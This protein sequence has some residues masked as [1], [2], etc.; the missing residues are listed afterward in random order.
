MTKKIY[1][2]EFETDAWHI[3]LAASEKGVVKISYGKD[4]KFEFFSWLEDHFPGY[5]Y[6]KDDSRLSK[7]AD[8]VR[9]Y[10][11]GRIKK[12]DFPIDLQEKGFFKKVLLALRKVPYGKTVTYGDLAAMAGSPRASRAAGT[13]CSKNPLPLVIPCHRVI[14]SGNRLGGYGGGER[15]KRKLLE[16]EGV[17][18]LKD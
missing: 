11:D 18:G 13:A 10:I 2:T 9:D 3:F 1:F 16:N 12:I 17:T 7:Y 15:L 4:S 6:E 5:M 8:Q 14:A